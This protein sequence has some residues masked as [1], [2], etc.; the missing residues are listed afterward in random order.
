MSTTPRIATTAAAILALAAASA[1]IAT[2]RPLDDPAIAGKQ[3]PTVVY[4]RP[5]K[6]M[7]PASPA[8]ASGGVL[9]R[10]AALRSLTQQERQRVAGISALS[11]KQL[12]AAFGV[13][14]PAANEAS[15]TQAVVRVQV[16][17]SGFD[18]GDAGISA[19]GGLALA[20]LGVGGGLVVSQRRGRTRHGTT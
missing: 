16:P 13:A 3:A 7:I 18:W 4:S 10:S 9:D 12:A 8:A 6:S 19:A 17:P 15:A 14:P 5:D 2:A 11:D 1:P 20:M